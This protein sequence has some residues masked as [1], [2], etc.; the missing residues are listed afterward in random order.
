[1]KKCACLKCWICLIH[2]EIESMQD[3]IVFDSHRVNFHT[4][5]DSRMMFLKNIIRPHQTSSWLQQTSLPELKPKVW[6]APVVVV[7]VAVSKLKRTV[8]YLKV[9]RGKRRMVREVHALNP[10][11]QYDDLLRANIH[12]QVAI[13]GLHQQGNNVNSTVN[14]WMVVEV[15][16]V[17]YQIPAQRMIIGQSNHQSQ[18]NHVQQVS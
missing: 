9:A 5:S 7:A 12:H 8:K 13:W 2:Y 10:R 4:K 16:R 18:G 17:H 15:V 14:N 3:D 6:W 1:M 11:H